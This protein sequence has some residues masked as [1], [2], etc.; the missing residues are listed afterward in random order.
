MLS[1]TGNTGWRA[2]SHRLFR[3]QS[4]ARSRKDTLEISHALTYSTTQ[5]VSSFQLSD[6]QAFTL[7]TMR[8]PG[9]R[10]E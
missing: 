8:M 4:A 2:F 6:Q 3:R 9:E 5:L 7:S 1:G 10:S